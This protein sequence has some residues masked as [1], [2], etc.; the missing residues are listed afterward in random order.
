MVAL[1]IITFV[2]MNNIQALHKVIGMW[3]LLRGA[4][5]MFALSRAQ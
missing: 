3:A 4:R 1:M 5:L 2:D